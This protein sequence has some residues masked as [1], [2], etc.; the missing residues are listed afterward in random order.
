MALYRLVL[1]SSF[2]TEFRPIFPEM[3]L[4]KEAGRLA[5]LT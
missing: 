1:I 3:L 4:R 2:F 5:T